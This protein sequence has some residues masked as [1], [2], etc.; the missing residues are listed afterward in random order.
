MGGRLL[1]HVLRIELLDVGGSDA[2]SNEQAQ[3]PR[4]GRRQDV[5]DGCAGHHDHPA[6]EPAHLPAQV[7][8]EPAGDLLVLA[9][10]AVE[11][12][13]A[14]RQ[15]PMLGQVAVG[16]RIHRG[17][18]APGNLTQRPP[19]DRGGVLGDQIRHPR[20]ADR[21]VAIQGPNQDLEHGGVSEPGVVVHRDQNVSPGDGRPRVDRPSLP[22]V[23]PHDDHLELPKPLD[24]QL[25][26][27]SLEG[28]AS[29]PVRDRDDDGD[30][31]G[32]STATV[33]DDVDLRD[34]AFV[35][36]PDELPA[37]GHRALRDRVVHPEKTTRSSGGEGGCSFHRM[38]RWRR[39]A[40]F[41]AI[42]SL[43]WP[44]GRAS[45]W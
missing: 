33:A 37:P 6:A 18:T 3:D 39:Y 45:K 44:A 25:L 34:G 35:R 36:I 15:T 8:V 27:Q 14:N 26:E 43:L 1:D 24:A 4:Q 32:R 5:V 10:D 21:R 16:H 20:G 30:S 38:S 7:G 31:G 28:L 2:V 29:G 13:P 22:P 23:A 11:Q 40:Q 17:G 19:D 9:S 12:V 42:V 41:W